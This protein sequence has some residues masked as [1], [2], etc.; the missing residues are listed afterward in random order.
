M[1]AL[2]YCDWLCT[3]LAVQS[4]SVHNTNF[5]KV[6]LLQ[7]T[8]THLLPMPR[9][10]GASV[11]A[12]FAEQCL[13][14]T[15]MLYDQQLGILLLLQRLIEH[16]A[17]ST[18]SVDHT[19][20]LDGVRMAVPAC[21]A[22]VAD[23]VMRQIAT[24]K[25]SRVCVHLRGTHERKGFSI[26]SAALAKQSADVPVHTAELNTARTC[27]LD[28]FGEQVRSAHERAADRCEACTC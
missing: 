8:F 19:H 7:H 18:L 26:G 16:F 12:V 22:A 17:A 28:Y 25:P 11:G 10:E 4:H 24:D 9:P 13:W 20:S 3:A 2:R 15:P 1:A 5:L 14:R 23:C 21:V 27:V 6:A